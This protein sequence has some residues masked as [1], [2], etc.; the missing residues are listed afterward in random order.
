MVAVRVS[1]AGALASV[2]AKKARPRLKAI[3]SFRCTQ[4]SG[5]LAV[6]LQSV[7]AIDRQAKSGTGQKVR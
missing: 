2:H 3:L 4:S 5:V 7:L 1:G 6:S